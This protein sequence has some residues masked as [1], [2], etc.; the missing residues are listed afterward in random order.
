MFDGPFRE[1]KGQKATLEEGDG[2]S[3]C[4]FEAFIQWL[5]AGEINFNAKD[6]SERIL[7]A[8]ELA[9]VGDM[10]TVP[11]L[12][13]PVA[14]YIKQIILSN[15]SKGSNCNIDFI[16][17]EHIDSAYI[18]PSEHPVRQ[19]L[20]KASVE[21]FMLASSFKL[22]DA[23]LENPEFAADLIQEFDGPFRKF[24]SRLMEMCTCNF[25]YKL[26]RDPFTGRVW[27]AND[28]DDYDL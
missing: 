19:V 14:Q 10:W 7:N 1:G 12:E 3:V 8:I 16:S 15:R 22:L 21:A 27:P 20:A 9:R 5:Y 18:L 13:A 26:F 17:S 2:L 28:E 4:T 25:R 24:F 11:E 23:A 6:R